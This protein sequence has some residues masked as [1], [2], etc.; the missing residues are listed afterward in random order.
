MHM[1]KIKKQNLKTLGKIQLSLKKSN[2]IKQNEHNWLLS[3]L[4]AQTRPAAYLKLRIHYTQ[5][6]KLRFQQTITDCDYFDWS[7][8]YKIQA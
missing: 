2:Q 3:L 8:F 7:M 5:F 1:E 6:A 4:S